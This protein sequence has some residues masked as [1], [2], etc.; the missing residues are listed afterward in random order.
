MIIDRLFAL[1]LLLA[2]I[3]IFQTKKF[4]WKNMNLDFSNYY[5]NMYIGLGLILFGL[6]WFYTTF[7]SRTKYKQ[8][9][10]F[11]KCPKC[12]KSYN[13]SELK[14]GMCHTCNV[15]TIE[16]DEYFKKYP[17]ELEDITDK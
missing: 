12:K 8:K 14:D 9:I 2:G 6:I 17:K 1:I 15:K 13:Y 7:N 5:L 16:M 4:S 11:F 10:E 3:I